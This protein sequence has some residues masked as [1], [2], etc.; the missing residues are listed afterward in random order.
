MIIEEDVFSQNFKPSTYVTKRQLGGHGITVWTNDPEGKVYEL[1]T[2]I[3]EPTQLQLLFLKLS[4]GE[5]R[6]K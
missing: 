3:P 6:G 4:A 5:G 1:Q 2:Q